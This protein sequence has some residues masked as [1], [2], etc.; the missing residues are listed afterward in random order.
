MGLERL[1][2]P[3]QAMLPWSRPKLG[4]EILGLLFSGLACQGDL[5]QIHDIFYEKGKNHTLPWVWHV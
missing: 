1:P 4:M 5:R 2:K 3:A